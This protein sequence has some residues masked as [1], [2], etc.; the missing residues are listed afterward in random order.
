M[1]VLLPNFDKSYCNII[2]VCGRVKD[3]VDVDDYPQEEV[4]ARY[5]VPGSYAYIR[6]TPFGK[7]DLHLHIDCAL[8]NFFSKNNRPETN[9]RKDEVLKVLDKLQSASVQASIIGGFIV[10]LIDIP[11]NGLI[12][13]LSAEQ[14]SGTM[15]L[16]MVRGEFRIKGAPVYGIDWRLVGHERKAYIRVKIRMLLTIDEQYLINAYNLVIEQF[17]ML[18]LGESS[19]V[20]NTS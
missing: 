20:D 8:Y 14:K 1:R 19:I 5:R 13:G 2:T 7:T 9:S 4:I 17:K 11:D 6:T 16:R 12:R 18:V 15:S 10:P 3:D